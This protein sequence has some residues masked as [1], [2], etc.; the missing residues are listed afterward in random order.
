[1]TGMVEIYWHIFEA[2]F[3]WLLSSKISQL[4]T[5]KL[6][7]VLFKFPN[8]RFWNFFNVIQDK[9]TRRVDILWLFLRKVQKI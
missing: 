7:E 2:N 9:I 5:L 1:M 3:N 6:L 8:K 4:E